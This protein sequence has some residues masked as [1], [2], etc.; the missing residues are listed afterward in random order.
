M[1]PPTPE[2]DR[3]R[4]V[5]DEAATISEFLDWL[6]SENLSICSLVKNRAN[7]SDSYYAPI[8]TSNEKLLAAFFEIDLDKIE[9]ER[10]LLLEQIRQESTETK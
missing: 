6:G 10:R 3:M 5:R 4:G 9:K 2:L 1:I 7:P 8:S